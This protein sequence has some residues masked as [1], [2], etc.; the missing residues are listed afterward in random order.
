TTAAIALLAITFVLATPAFAHQ[1]PYSWLELHMTPNGIDGSMTAHIVDLSHEAGIVTPESLL[2]LS[3]L[4]S[5]RA[6]LLSAVRPHIE[7][8]AD[9][10]P[11][12]PSWGELTAVP[13]RR[14]IRFDWNAAWDRRPA[15]VEVRGPLFPY[16]PAHET[17]VHIYEGDKLVQQ[18]LLDHSHTTFT[19]Y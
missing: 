6:A 12:D 10:H 17:Y 8:N 4:D 15:A 11:I 7:I 3:Y 19:A 2:D 16:D 14:A 1:E 5:H 9:G 13:S 18:E